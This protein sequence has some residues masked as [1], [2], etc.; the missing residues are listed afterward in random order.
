MFLL[1]FISD[2]SHSTQI[3]RQLIPFI[4]SDEQKVII[5]VDFVKDAAPLAISLR[6]AGYKSCSYHGQKMSAHDK[7]QSIESWRNNDV[8]IMVCTTA[9]GMGIDQ[10]DVE[11]VMRIGCPPT[12]EAMIQEFGRGG[13]D[14][15]PAKGQYIH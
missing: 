3:A 8:K 4:E 6:Q 2:N 13:R 1:S 15:R 14:G 9:F 12:L 11:I 10:H 5:Y 7:I